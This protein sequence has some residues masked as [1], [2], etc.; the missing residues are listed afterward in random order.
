MQDI[1]VAGYRLLPS[2]IPFESGGDE[3]KVRTAAGFLQHLA[4]L[5]GSLGAAHRRTHAMTRGQ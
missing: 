2:L 4:D 1:L 3:R 5:G